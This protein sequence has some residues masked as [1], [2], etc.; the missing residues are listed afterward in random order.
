MIAIVLPFNSML[1]LLIHRIDISGLE[2]AVIADEG[3]HHS[4]VSSI[5][6]ACSFAASLKMS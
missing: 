3:E 4:A 6:M 5:L 1:A 2:V